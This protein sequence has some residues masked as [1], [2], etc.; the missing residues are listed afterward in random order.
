MRLLKLEMK[1]VLK[2]RLTFLLLSFS[3]FLAFVMAWL[4]ITFSYHSYTDEDGNTVEL[5]GLKAIA[6]EKELQADIAGI[7]VPEKVRQAVERYQVCLTKYGVENSW[8]LQEGVY[9]AEIFPYAPMLHGIKEAFANSD[10]GMAASIM[11]I[12]PAEVDRYYDVCAERIV[13][14]MATEQ[15]N[16]PSAQNVAVTMYHKVKKPY[17]FFPGYSTD[18]MDYQ[19]LLSF[20]IV[21]FGA[22]IVAPIFTS[23]YQTGADDILRCTKCGT[24][25]LSTAKIVSAFLICGID[26]T[27]CAMIYLL[28]SNSLW[29]WECTKTS[30]QM[31]YSI[32]NLPNMNIGQLQY[33]LVFSG[34]LC[35]LA[36]TA[37]TLFLSAKYRNVV[38]S[39]SMALLFVFLPIILYMALPDEIGKWIYSVLP[40]GGVGL[41][42]SLLYAMIDFK[43]W[44]IGNF[45]I[46]LPHVMIGAYLIEIPLFG[47]LTAISY[48][49][50]QSA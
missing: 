2:S 7:V 1:R 47:I 12:A 32:L 15:K 45:A 40:A 25:K 11:E 28:V 14:L 37:F 41:Q 9:Q 50:R 18:A 17:L 20:L 29:G 44:N 21:I 23:D 6:Y 48:I 24:V 43:F 49:R 35:I 19:L 26:Y 16:H 3:I 42:T 5:T 46:W 8:D 38:T 4:P 30:M 22:V 39:L 31:L 13:S 27:V 10:T 34:L 36:T 33:F